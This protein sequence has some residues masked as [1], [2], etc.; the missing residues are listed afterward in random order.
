MIGEIAMDQAGFFDLYLCAELF[1]SPC[2]K[3]LF[4]LP[5]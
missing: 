1:M 5:G 3:K 2:G 4:P